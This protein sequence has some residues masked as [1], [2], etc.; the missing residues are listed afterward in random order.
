MTFDE[1]SRCSRK[2]PKID[3]EG[4][5]EIVC[6]WCGY[7]HCDSWERRDEDD[8]ECSDCGKPF[9]YSRDTWVSYS[10]SKNED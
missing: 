4:T 2:E 6:P 3:H 1:R 10:T 8:T 9:Y 7:T 5:N